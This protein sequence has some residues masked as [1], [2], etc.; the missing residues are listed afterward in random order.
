MYEFT[1]EERVYLWQGVLYNQEKTKEGL[2]NP[3]LEDDVRNGLLKKLS[4]LNY[5]EDKLIFQGEIK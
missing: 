4:V 3:Y 2:E 5:L 1:Y